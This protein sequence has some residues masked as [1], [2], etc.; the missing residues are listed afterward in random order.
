MNDKYKG[1]V[2]LLES[3]G[4]KSIALQLVAKKF[5]SVSRII[6]NYVPKLKEPLDKIKSGKGELTKEDSKKTER[7][8]TTLFNDLKKELS[9]LTPGKM[10]IMIAAVIVIATIN[11]LMGLLSLII[12]HSIR[13]DVGPKT[14]RRISL[15]MNLV[16]FGIMTPAIEELAKYIAVQKGSG[17]TFGIFFGIM[18]NIVNDWVRNGK[19][20]SNTLMLP[21]RITLHGGLATIQHEFTNAGHPKLGL[22]V[23]WLVHGLWNSFLIIMAN[24]KT[25]QL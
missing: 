24:L 6:R 8:V 5:P 22:S 14:A 4:S 7:S 10:G 13:F 16:V 20:L 17:L 18:E 1:V 3:D 2:F 11:I 12:Q 25:L 21:Y 23:A 15:V 19:T 9:K